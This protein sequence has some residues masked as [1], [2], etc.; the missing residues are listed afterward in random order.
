MVDINKYAPHISGPL[1]FVGRDKAPSNLS[2]GAVETACSKDT[3]NLR[4]TNGF[5]DPNPSVRKIWGCILYCNTSV[6]SGVSVCDGMWMA[7]CLELG[8]EAELGVLEL[9]WVEPR[10]T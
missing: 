7:R 1:F 5:Q 8:P 10:C 6:G 4:P 3:A 2:P 9:S